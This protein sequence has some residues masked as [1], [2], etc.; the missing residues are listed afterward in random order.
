MPGPRK[1][2][3]SKQHKIPFKK[4][5]QSVTLSLTIHLVLRFFFPLLFQSLPSEIYSLK[6]R[7]N[8]FRYYAGS[9]LSS[10]VKLSRCF[11]REYILGGRE[12]LH[13]FQIFPVFLPVFLRF[14]SSSTQ[15]SPP[16]FLVFPFSLSFAVFLP[17]F[18]AVLRFSKAR[19]PRLPL[20]PILSPSL[21]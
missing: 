14:F 12:F 10:C 16:F 4:I 1:F 5:L 15:F 19:R 17:V 8:T 20:F 13:I 9:V 6:L 3:I 2:Y 7:S 11:H 18:L 21:L